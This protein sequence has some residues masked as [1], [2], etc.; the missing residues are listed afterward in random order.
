MEIQNRLDGIAEGLRFL[1]HQYE[2]DLLQILKP[3]TV[4]RG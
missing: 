3:E 1:K 4:K 2:S